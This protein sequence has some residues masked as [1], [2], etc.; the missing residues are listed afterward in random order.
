MKKKSNKI[1]KAIVVCFV[2]L[3]S[4]GLFYINASI[5]VFATTDEQEISDV[6][7]SQEIEESPQKEVV[8][9]QYDETKKKEE[10]KENTVDEIITNETLSDVEKIDEKNEKVKMSENTSISVHDENDLINAI[11]SGDDRVTIILDTTITLSNVVNIPTGKEIYLESKD[12]T[13][14][15]LFSASGKRHFIVNGKLSLGNIVLEG[16]SPNYE[17][18]IGGGIDVNNGKLIINEE[19]IIRFCY[20]GASGGAINAI[21]NSE[22]IMNG[23]SIANNSTPTYGSNGGG[24]S[25]T[26][27]AFIMNAGAIDANKSVWG[28][29][30]GVGADAIFTMNGGTIS[31]NTTHNP[32]SGYGGGVQVATH[33]KFILEGGTLSGNSSS[34]GGAVYVGEGTYIGGSPFDYSNFEMN[35]GTIIHNTSTSIGGG[36]A[37]SANGNMLMNGGIITDNKA[38]NIG[39]GVAVSIQGYNS[40]SNG[41]SFIMNNGEIS[42][43]EASNMYGGGLVILGDPINSAYLT[44]EIGDKNN[45]SS[46]YPVIKDNVAKK[47]GGAIALYAGEINMYAGEITGNTSGSAGGG[48]YLFG[49]ATFNVT[50]SQIGGEDNQANISAGSGGGIATADDGETV[51]IKNSKIIGNVSNSTTFGGGGIYIGDKDIVSIENSVVEKNRSNNGGGIFVKGKGKLDVISNT[52]FNNNKAENEGGAIYTADFSDYQNLRDTDYQ[53]LTIDQTTEFHDNI[54]NQPYA[55][56]EIANS[57]VNIQHERTSL[58]DYKGNYVHPINNYDINYCST[59]PLAIYCKI[60]YNPN[61]GIG[62]IYSDVKEISTDYTIL[63]ENNNSFAFRK[64]GFDFVGWNTLADG[65]G[66]VYQANDVVVLNENM[67][68]YAQWKEELK[69]PANPEEQNKPEEPKNP[70]NPENPKNPNHPIGEN[71]NKVTGISTIETGDYSNMRETIVLLLLSFGAIVVINKERKVS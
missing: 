21:Q 52:I 70:S 7:E 63:T 62:T 64:E 56:P 59:T 47:E 37:M 5:V 32:N 68:L 57:Y 26:A 44:I 22:V 34:T 71:D 65:S 20:R 28:G 8:T 40:K 58:I 60:T 19:T 67:T 17:A 61:G 27:S 35:G 49:N 36:V 50:N 41:V 1:L 16:N 12:G 69:E 33:G 29:G 9:K 6:E 42:D 55:A 18:N 39:G 4:I 38:V 13:K 45:P 24:I 25:I 30:V 46:S 3:S 15:K 51:T 48:V 66:D 14:N 53:N 31:N 10:R 2:A 23:G 54:A 43:N 11:M